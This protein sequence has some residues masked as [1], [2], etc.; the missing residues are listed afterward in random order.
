MK[1]GLEPLTVLLA[2]PRGFC[3]GVERAI[4]AVEDALAQTG[5]PVYVRHE[6]VHN[7]F[8]VNALKRKGAVF[9]DELSEIPDGA[10]AIFS[11]HGVSR[12]V[13]REAA[14]RDLAVLD[15][16]CPLVRRVHVEGRR[17][18]QAGRDVI[19]IGH[20]SH[21]EV[22]GTIGQI[23]GIV[24]VVETVEDVRSV[25]VSDPDHVAY[26]TQT[27]LSVDDTRGIIA[28]LRMRFPAIQG[29]DTKTICYATQNRQLAVR[30]IAA[31]AERV[32]VCGSGNSSNTA[33][34]REVAESHG[35]PALLMQDP[36]DLT[37]SFIDGVAVI[38]LTA[39][40]SA[41]EQMI[42]QALARLAEWRDLSVEEVRVTHEGTRFAPVDLSFLTH[43]AA[44]VS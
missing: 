10:V 27:T 37:L 34:L 9:V 5:K 41:P 7:G 4:Q 1:R 2:A 19:L 14:G 35:R 36:R 33:R 8:V 25:C 38:G 12:E 32:I 24:H 30:V 43:Q 28:A 21:V 40:A 13:E 15:A 3:A 20:R 6:I 18:A 31:R 29:P 11:A 42:N 17:H 16:T 22:E 23:A 39:G 26:V 44:S